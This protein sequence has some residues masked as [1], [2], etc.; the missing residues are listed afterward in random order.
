MCR[1]D[2]FLYVKE[3]M[4]NSSSGVQVDDF[5]YEII[6]SS[7]H[8]KKMYRFFISYLVRMYLI[9]ED[10]DPED[11]NNV[12]VFFDGYG[13]TERRWIED[14]LHKILVCAVRYYKTNDPKYQRHL[15][16]ERERRLLLI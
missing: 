16:R 14:F 3:K 7:P 1:H 4:S 2:F 12:F 11:Q 13:R 10:V 8:F 15:K 6:T 5:S 9:R